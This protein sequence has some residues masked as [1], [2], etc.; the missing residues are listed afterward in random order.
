MPT[1]YING[2]KHYKLS[3]LVYFS[4][5]IYLR[6]VKIIAL[7]LLHLL[8]IGCYEDPGNE[9]VCCYDKRLVC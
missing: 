4:T 5:C 7:T 1:V 3:F 2:I 9:I 6:P 8:G